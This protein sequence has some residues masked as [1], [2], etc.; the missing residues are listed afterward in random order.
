M[1]YYGATTLLNG[2]GKYSI[3]ENT[4]LDDWWV[5]RN[6]C[7]ARRV[8][9]TILKPISDSLSL[10]NTRLIVSENSLGK[11]VVKS[12]AWISS[13]FYTNWNMSLCLTNSLRLFHV[14]IYCLFTAVQYIF[15]SYTECCSM[16]WGIVMIQKALP[17]TISFQSLQMYIC[18][19]NSS[20]LSV[21]SLLYTMLFLWFDS[22]Q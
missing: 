4:L 3:A 17:D 6:F 20:H 13:Q 10:A 7:R 12:S 1:I 21:G 14:L 9:V 16:G 18:I 2:I 11:Y 15:I 5:M 22:T 19:L 8:E